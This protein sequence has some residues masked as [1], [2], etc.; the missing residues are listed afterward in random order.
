MYYY[1][2]VANSKPSAKRL[3]QHVTPH[4]A[5]KWYELG[6]ELLDEKEECKL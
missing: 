1:C 5:A 6:L 4:V 3:Q 2:Y